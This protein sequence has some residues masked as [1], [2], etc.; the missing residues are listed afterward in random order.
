MHEC[1]AGNDKGMY[2]GGGVYFLYTFFI[3][4]LDWHLVLKVSEFNAK[5]L[6]F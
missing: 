6:A 2:G 4:N 1:M 3:R 5:I